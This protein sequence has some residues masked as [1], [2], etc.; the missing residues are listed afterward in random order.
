MHEVLGDLTVVAQYLLPKTLDKDFA[1]SG[2][3]DAC[4]H[5]F[6]EA[7]PLLEPKHV[8]E[9]VAIPP[10]ITQRRQHDR[11]EMLLSVLVLLEGDDAVLMLKH[12]V[13]SNNHELFQVRV[14]DLGV[15]E[16]P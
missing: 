2:I 7:L 6:F 15:E 11:D 10:L 5:D 1:M 16:V 4:V 13:E 12:H 14:C 8:L 3:S 9:C